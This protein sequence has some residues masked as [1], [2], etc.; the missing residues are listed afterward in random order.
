MNNMLATKLDLQRVA[1]QQDVVLLRQEIA[2]L[3]QELLDMRA[4]LRRQS[5]NGS[6]QVVRS[7]DISFDNLMRKI[8]QVERKLVFRFGVM[9]FSGCG[10]TVLFAWYWT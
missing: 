9:F 7:R 10:L 8:D 6:N 3:R 4:Q 5:E 1:S 2:L